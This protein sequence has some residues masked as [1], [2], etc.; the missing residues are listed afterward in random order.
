MD[1]VYRTKR[2]PSEGE[3]VI[4][5]SFGRY[6]GGKGANQAVAAAR[7]GAQVTMVGKLGCDSFGD[8]MVATLSAEGIDVSNVLREDS[9]ATGVSSVMLDEHG[10]NRIIIIP[11]SNLKYTSQELRSVEHLIRSSKMIVMQLEMDMSIVEE[12]VSLAS[13]YGVPVLLNP[14]PAQKLSDHVMRSVDYLTP[15]ETEAEILTGVKV[16]D[17]ASAEEAARILL[18]KGVKNVVITL[19]E[20]GALIASKGTVQHIPG[21]RVDPVD[22]VAA[23]D[24]FNGALAVGIIRGESLVQATRFANAVGAL[25]VTKNGA[26]PSL[27]SRQAVQEFL[28]N[29]DS[30]DAST[31]QD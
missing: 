21:F 2:I 13:K 18:S 4:G 28:Y 3:T 25:T 14:A 9:T 30:V 10:N 24:A 15:N 31:L 20:K 16:I 19:A 6:P 29:N 5:T 12:G 11:G 17:T 1:L 23:G 22:T 26:I 7:L 27:P 8:E